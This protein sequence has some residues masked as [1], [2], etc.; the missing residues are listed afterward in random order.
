MRRGFSIFLILMFGLG[1]LSSLID[2]SEDANL[3]ACC[4]RHGAHHCAFEARIAASAEQAQSGKTPVVSAPMTCPSYPGA[5]A[6]LS[7]PSQALAAA[8]RHAGALQPFE[9]VQVATLTAPLS[10]P[11]QTHAGRGPPATN[12]S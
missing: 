9:Y 6:L 1:P 7:A 8:S 5:I 12:L 3:P 10:K 2:G 4:R 11:A